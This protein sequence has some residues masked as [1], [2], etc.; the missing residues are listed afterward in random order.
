MPLAQG[1]CAVAASSRENRSNNMSTLW[2]LINM[3]DEEKVNA[4]NLVQTIVQHLALWESINL[5]LTATDQEQLTYTVLIVSAE[6]PNRDGSIYL[7][8]FHRQLPNY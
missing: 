7:S 1:S 8:S 6:I 4:K 3:A 5:I 2:M